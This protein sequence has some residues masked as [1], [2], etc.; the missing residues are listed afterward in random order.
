M[1]AD[2]HS[3]GGPATRRAILLGLALAMPAGGSFAQAIG[4]SDEIV[5]DPN[6]GAALFG[7]DPVAYFL[8]QRAVPGRANLQTVYAGRVWHFVSRANQAAFETDPQPYIPAFG[9]HDPLGIA[10]GFAVA[11]NPQTFALAEN[12]LFLFRDEGS[13]SLFLRDPARL[14]LAERN[15]PLVRRDMVP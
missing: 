7:F 3:D 11:G 9:G 13:R 15:W 4:L 10:A 5:A 2:R 12:R 8:D 14:D 1:A 6:S